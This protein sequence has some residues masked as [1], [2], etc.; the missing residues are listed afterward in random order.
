VNQGDVF[1][2]TFKAPDKRRPVLV[3]TRDSAI[4]FLTS[5]TIAPNTTTIRTIPSEVPLS[6][7]DRMFAESAV[8][9]DDIQ[10]APKSRI[11][12]FI[13]H[14]WPQPMRRVR[15]A[16]EFALGLDAAPVE[17]APPDEPCSQ[18]LTRRFLLGY[19]PGQRSPDKAAPSS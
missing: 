12:A 19:N 7:A 2:H 17:G 15:R 4:S 14:L 1:S 5:V 18:L 16:I 9:L 3:F 10:T 6:E 13:T 11:G 8:N